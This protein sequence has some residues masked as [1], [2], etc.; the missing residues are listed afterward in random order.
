M[1]ERDKKV[2]IRRKL[3]KLV[4]MEALESRSAIV[5]EDLPKRAPERMIKDVR[6][7]QLRLRIYRSAFSSTKNVIMEKAK[8]FGVPIILVN[9]AY[10]SFKC[11]VHGSK[12]IYRPDGGLCPKGYVCVSRKERWHRDVVSLYNLMRRAGDV[13]QMP[14]S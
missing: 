11:P 1:R 7:S 3:A 4:V 13:S 9:S 6:D 2:N 8:E 10:T 12:I 14:F 5:L